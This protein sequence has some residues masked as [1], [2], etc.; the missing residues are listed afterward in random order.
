MQLG[1]IPLCQPDVIQVINDPRPCLS[2]FVVSMQTE[3]CK[4]SLQTSLAYQG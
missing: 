1:A 4:H 3:V 2:V